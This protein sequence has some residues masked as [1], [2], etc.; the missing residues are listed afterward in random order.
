MEDV[1]IRLT[2]GFK[3]LKLDEA[4]SKGSES[5]WRLAASFKN[6]MAKRQSENQQDKLGS[7][8]SSTSSCGGEKD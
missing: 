8:G 3:D 4:L 5:V 6:D 1:G 2:H 7:A